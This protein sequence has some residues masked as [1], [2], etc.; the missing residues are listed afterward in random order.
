MAEFI[1]LTHFSFS[2]LALCC[3]DGR[4]EAFLK[5]DQVESSG[6]FL[7]STQAWTCMLSCILASSPWRYEDCIKLNA[8]VSQE[9]TLR[10]RILGKLY[11]SGYLYSAGKWC[12]ENSGC[13]S[14]RNI[15]W[16]CKWKSTTKTGINIPVHTWPCPFRSRN[17]RCLKTVL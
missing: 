16:V 17:R 8:R 13:F 10:N 4:E 2:W 15:F 9:C 1:V 14:C 11:N 7:L 6:S 12:T 3:V 5:T